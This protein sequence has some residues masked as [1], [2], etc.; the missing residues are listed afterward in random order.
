M[1][2]CYLEVD[3]CNIVGGLCRIMIRA[4]FLVGMPASGQVRKRKYGCVGRSKNSESHHCEVSELCAVV[5]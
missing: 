4:I 2:D 1:A 3:G 5:S